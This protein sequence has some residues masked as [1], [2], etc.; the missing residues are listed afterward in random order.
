[1]ESI[2]GLGT[3][4]VTAGPLLEQDQLETGCP[5]RQFYVQFDNL[6]G[7]QPLLHVESEGLRGDGVSVS[8]GEEVPGG[9]MLR[10][11]PGHMLQTVERT[12]Q[13]RGGVR[14]EG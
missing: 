6:P 10:P 7:D 14:G 4:T 11:I 3:F 12:P 13:V 2:P 8:V 1:M 9:L 5:G